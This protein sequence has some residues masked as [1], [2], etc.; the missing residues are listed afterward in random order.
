MASS[1]PALKD[2]KPGDELKGLDD[3]DGAL[4]IRGG[5]AALMRSD[6]YRLSALL[7]PGDC[8][9]LAGSRFKA[10]ALT[11]VYLAREE[12]PS[13]G[14]PDFILRHCFR[15]GHLA[16]FE[17]MADFLL[18]IPLRLRSVLRPVDWTYEMPLTQEQLGELVGLSGVHTNR[19]LQALRR[20]GLI[21]AHH[22]KVTIREPG[23]IARLVNIE[24]PSPPHNDS[25]ATVPICHTDRVS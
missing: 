19:T 24:L 21:E 1:Q 3:Q 25:R 17:R 6:D 7:L 9:S 11:S 15:L 16:A 10:V 5:W 18:E 12:S 20:E 13:D 2:I 22:G 14:V 23:R 4:V 8:V